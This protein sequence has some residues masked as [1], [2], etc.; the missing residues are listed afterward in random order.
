MSTL[1]FTMFSKLFR[2]AFWA[3]NALTVLPTIH[4]LTE[5]CELRIKYASAL[6]MHNPISVKL[7]D[8]SMIQRVIESEPT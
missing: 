6:H 1:R 3:V 5:A 7:L 4:D 8:F 2:K